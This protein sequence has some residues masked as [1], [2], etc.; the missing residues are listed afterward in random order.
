MLSSRVEAVSPPC[1]PPPTPEDSRALRDVLGAFP[2]GVAVITTRGINGAPVGMT[3]SSFSSLSLDPPLV[4]WSIDKK[5]GCMDDFAH[6]RY[7]AIH[8]LSQEQ[9]ALSAKFAQKGIDKF[10][11]TL[12]TAGMDETPLLP[13]YCARLECE[14]T[15]RYE[16]GD[17]IIM[18]GKVLVM[19]QD[20]SREPL[21]YHRGN[22]ARLE[23]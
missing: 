5:A 13:E 6:C 2:T 19:D 22:Y 18:V 7:Y 3:A 20:E 21:V 23:P 9:Q 1:T 11:D 15:E 12:H 4:L 16:G 8:A 10:S 17:H 14:V